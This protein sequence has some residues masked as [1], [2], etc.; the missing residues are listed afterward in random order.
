MA[1]YARDTMQ[2]VRQRG[3][4]F[5]M[6]PAMLGLAAAVFRGFA[7]AGEFEFGWFQ[8]YHELNFS[9]NYRSTALFWEMHVGGA[10]LDGFWLRWP[11]QRVGSTLNCPSF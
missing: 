2:P 8:G 1:E 4:R 6:L 3:V 9:S 11:A 10:A 5:G 7:D